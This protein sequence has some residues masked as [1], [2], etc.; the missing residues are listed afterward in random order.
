MCTG[1]Y[2][3]AWCGGARPCHVDLTTLGRIWLLP[4]LGWLRRCGLRRCRRRQKRDLF[5]VPGCPPLAAAR[6]DCIVHEH[7]VASRSGLGCR[8]AGAAQHWPARARHPRSPRCPPWPETARHLHTDGKEATK[9]AEDAFSTV[10]ENVP[11]SEEAA[12]LS[13][14]ISTEPTTAASAKVEAAVPLTQHAL[15]QTQA[16]T[17]PVQ[18]IL[19][20][21][22]GENGEDKRYLFPNAH[23]K[24]GC[25]SSS[26]A[27]AW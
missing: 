3:L 17:R 5:W 26:S 20:M 23:F 15:D 11:G 12:H 9:H 8:A 6:Q 4:A 14:H 18:L 7:R 13:R 10:G 21:S 16:R 22:A 27:R 19:K 1:H 24:C 2:I 25:Q